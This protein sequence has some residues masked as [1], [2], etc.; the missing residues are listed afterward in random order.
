MLCSVPCLLKSFVSHH[1]KILPILLIV[2][3]HSYICMFVKCIYQLNEPSTF[4]FCYVF[5]M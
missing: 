1:V 5:A 2:Y 3:V 4:Y